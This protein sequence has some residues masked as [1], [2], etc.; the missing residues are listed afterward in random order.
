MYVQ[1]PFNR[2]ALSFGGADT[3]DNYQLKLRA[4]RIILKD[5]VR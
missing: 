1:G 5:S 2:H 4:Q 3:A